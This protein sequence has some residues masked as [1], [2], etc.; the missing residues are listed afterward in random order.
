MV[1]FSQ[2][3]VQIAISALVESRW[4]ISYAFLLTSDQQFVTITVSLGVCRRLE[5][6]VRVLATGG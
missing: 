4:L 5:L 1:L 2:V 3:S 6:D